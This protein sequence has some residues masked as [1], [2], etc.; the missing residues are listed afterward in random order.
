MTI[1]DDGTVF[2]LQPTEIYE[3]VPGGSPL[4][5]ADLTTPFPGRSGRGFTFGPG[6]DL[7]VAMQSGPGAILRVTRGGAMTVEYQSGSSG[8]FIDVRFDSAGDMLVLGNFGGKPIIKI[9]GGS[10]SVLVPAGTL[11][12]GAIQMTID[13]NDNL[14]VMSHNNVLQKVTPG[15]AVSTLFMVPTPG[16]FPL[17]IDDTDFDSYAAPSAMPGSSAHGRTLLIVALSLGLL[18]LPLLRKIG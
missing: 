18:L 2:I 13:A 9:S 16:S 4:L 17:D 5:L 14:Y 6:G 11:N 7:Y 1:A 3:A 8:D 10:E 12:S 15:G